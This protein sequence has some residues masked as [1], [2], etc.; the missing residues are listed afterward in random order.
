MLYYNHKNW[1]LFLYKSSW[2]ST[3]TL[4]SIMP[5]NLSVSAFRWPAW[6]RK[7]HS[8]SLSHPLLS[9]F[10][11]QQQSNCLHF[12]EKTWFFQFLV[13][14]LISWLQLTHAVL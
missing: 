14:E 9:S 2:L 5:Q 10:D 12:E 13:L 3:S 6:P 11:P 1:L 8:L 7:S 4:A